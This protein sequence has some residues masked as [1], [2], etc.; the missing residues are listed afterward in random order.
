MFIRKHIRILENF[1][2]FPYADYEPTGR[3]IFEIQFIHK[4]GHELEKPTSPF[5][6]ISFESHGFLHFLQFL[7]F[8]ACFRLKP[9]SGIACFH[10]YSQNLVSCFEVYGEVVFI[11]RK[12]S[13][14]D[15]VVDQFIGYERETVFPW[16]FDIV[17]LEQ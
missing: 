10:I 14:F 7:H 5:S 4:V 16:H 12:A 6:E 1:H 11:K 15:G 17:P 2:F 8:P 3:I 13:V 9:P